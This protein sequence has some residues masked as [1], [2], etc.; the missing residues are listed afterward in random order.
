MTRVLTRDERCLLAAGLAEAT[1]DIALGGP[2]TAA[3]RA[4]SGPHCHADRAEVVHE[5]W[6]AGEAL[7]RTPE[8]T[9]DLIPADLRSLVARA[10][11]VEARVAASGLDMTQARAAP[12]FAELAAAVRAVPSAAGSQ[13]LE[14]R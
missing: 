6:R 9:V 7:T 1:Q 4:Y 8:P 11:D 3:W 12:L 5:L 13:I 14:A 2:E 10:L